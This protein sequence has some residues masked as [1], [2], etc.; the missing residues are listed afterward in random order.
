MNNNTLLM[1]SP[2]Q[3][4]EIVAVYG[5]LRKDFGNY[6]ATGLNTQKRLGEDKTKEDY[7][8]RCFGSFP[9]MYPNGNTSVVVEVF[10]VTDPQVFY[11]L[12]RLEGHQEGVKSGYHREK[13]TLKSGIQA[14]TY[15]YYGN[16]YGNEVIHGDWKKYQN[17]K[18]KGIRSHKI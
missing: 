12:D 1:E 8:L 6:F 18:Q 4:K 7:T 3:F 9:G 16:H 14:W 13:I 17:E 5:T 10:E 2:K 11:N 15:V